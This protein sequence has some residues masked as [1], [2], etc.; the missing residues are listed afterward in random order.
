LTHANH[1]P[2]QESS[3][4]SRAANEKT[5]YDYLEVSANASPEIIRAAYRA[6]IQRY[7]PDKNPGFQTEAENLVK[8]INHAYTILSDPDQRR[9]YDEKIARTSARADTGA[10]NNSSS[11]ERNTNSNRETGG[12]RSADRG[13]NSADVA[14]VDD[15]VRYA[16]FW[17]RC[18]AWT[19]DCIVVGIPAGV[20]EYLFFG[21]DTLRSLLFGVFVWWLYTS[22]M[23]SGPRHATFGMRVTGMA[24]LHADS[25]TGITF[26][27]AT[28][29]YMAL[30]IT[31]W[32]GFLIQ[33]ITKRRQALHDLIARTIVVMQGRAGLA[34]GYVFAINAFMPGLA[35]LGIVAA[36]ALPAYQDY[37]TRARVSE[38]VHIGEQATKAVEAF[39]DRRDAIPGRIEDTGFSA[40]SPYV[41][42]VIVDKRNGVVRVT[43]SFAPIANKAMVFVPSVNADQTISW[44][45]FSDDIPKKYLPLSCRAELR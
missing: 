37:T 31:A 16:G 40:S 38:V 33:P 44:Q 20:L 36:V 15:P 32:I 11:R 2:S 3:N 45:C 29:R 17:R 21:E 8:V 24:V 18:A 35:V 25:H 39:A 22:L 42:S 14:D 4:R 10:A 28:V 26:G 27:R 7:H 19:V 12:A 1:A 13:A 41:A 6:L 34:P 23:L 43:T 9:Q 5:L 30:A